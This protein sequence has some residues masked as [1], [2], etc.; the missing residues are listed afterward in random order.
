[1]SVIEDKAKTKRGHRTIVLYLGKTLAE[2]QR[3]YEQATGGIARLIERIEEA[4]S[5]NWGSLANGHREECP[6]QLHFTHHGS[7]EREV[8]HFDGGRSRVI[9]HRVR[10][11]ECG[12]VFTVLPSFVARYKR[13]DTDAIEKF[14]TMLFITEDSYRM[15]GVGQA[16]GMDDQQAGTWVALDKAEGIAINP[17]ALWRLA[18]WVGQL[19]PA[20]LNLALGIKPPT[21]IIEDEKHM[22]QNGD[23]TYVPI[24]YAPNEA[25]IWWVDYLHS[26]SADALHDSLERFKALSDRLSGIR[27]ATVDGWDPAQEA[28]K[29][30]FPGLTLQECLLHATHKLDV[31]LA[32]YKRQRR[33]LRQPLSDQEEEDIF[34]AFHKV[35]YA[36]TPQEYQDALEALPDVFNQEPLASRK[37]SLQD[38][39]ALFQAWITDNRLALVSTALDQCMKFL[40]RK[41]DNMQTLHS[42]KSGL[43]TVNAWAITRNC[44]RFLKGAARAGLAPIQLAGAA[45]HGIPWMQI[46]NLVLSAWPTITL[47]ASLLVAST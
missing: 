42:D 28:L 41:Q 13:Y 38:K 37:Q 6:R 12:A 31:H 34:Q 9:I 22:T 39:Q 17:R 21:H 5:V 33:A 18:Q 15:A 19:S 23:K 30:A 10:C 26:V 24:V 25:L 45:L 2:Y 8:K 3:E 44:W 27:G 35:L 20:Q 16:F 4:D 29:R 46:V 47:A 7:Y 36:P 40:N 11:L 1:M 14:M 32:T 43:A